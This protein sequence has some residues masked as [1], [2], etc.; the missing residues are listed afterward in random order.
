MTEEQNNLIQKYLDDNLAP[1]EI[2]LF[3]KHFTND[4]EFAAEIKQYTDLRVALKTI[5]KTRIQA[6]KQSRIIKMMPLHYAIAA[7]V[8]LIIGIGSFFLFNNTPD[9]YNKEL[10][11]SYYVNPIVNKPE[12]FTRS[13]T[14][15]ID[16]QLEEDFAHAIDLMEKNHFAEAQMILESMET[17]SNSFFSDEVDWYRLLCLLRLGET[18]AAVELSAE[19]LNSNSIYNEK[20]RKIYNLIAAR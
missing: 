16:P 18:E 6:K 3:Q 7:S 19:I 1:E 2:L 13:E 11:A 20:A 14:N 8:A 17:A 4:K 12:V 5:S 10:Y 15:E 9:T